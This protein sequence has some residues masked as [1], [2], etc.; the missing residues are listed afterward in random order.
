VIEIR[1]TELLHLFNAIDPSPFRERDLDPAAE[2]FIVG[3]ASEAPRD[4]RILRDAIREFFGNRALGPGDALA[5]GDHLLN[6]T[7][8]PPLCWTVG[9]DRI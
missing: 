7:N 5:H 6:S 9:L 8:L 3:W 1:V 4:A 2:A